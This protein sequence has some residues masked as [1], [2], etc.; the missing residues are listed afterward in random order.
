MGT[1]PYQSLS[2]LQF[3]AHNIFA[4]ARFKGRERGSLGTRLKMTNGGD[5]EECIIVYP[6][7]HE[8]S[9]SASAIYQVSN[10]LRIQR[11]GTF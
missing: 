2:L 4:W 3:F 9:F 7:L 11:F 5:L 10:H 6:L 1:V 8:V